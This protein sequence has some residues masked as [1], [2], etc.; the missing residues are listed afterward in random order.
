MYLNKAVERIN[1]IKWDQARLIVLEENAE[2]GR[3]FL[4]RLAQF[5]KV[6]EIRPLKPMFTNIAKLLGDIE[7]V[8][9]SDYC[10]SVATDFLIKFNIYVYKIF[11]YYIQLVK[12]ADKHPEYIKYLSIYELLIRIFERGGLFVFR[13]NELEILNVISIPLAEWYERFVDRKRI[14]INN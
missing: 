3:E 5:Y 10:S 12:Y 4:R 13:I 1:N 9:I 2:L 6:E 11:G 14:D 7:Q 8:N